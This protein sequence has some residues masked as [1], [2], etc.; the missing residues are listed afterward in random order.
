LQTNTDFLGALAIYASEPDA[1]DP[2]EVRLLEALANDLAYGVVALRNRIER[3]RAEEAL[4]RAHED[5]ERQVE[6]RTAE[7][8]RANELLKQEVVERRRAEEELQQAKE[9]AEA[10]NRAKSAFLAN[11]SHEI[12]TPMNGVIGMTELALTTRLTPQQRDYLN[13]VKHS[14]EALL[15]L[16]NDIL[17]F[18]KIEAG[19]LE[20]ET[21]E[22]RL[23]DCLGDT[24][25][26]LGMRAGQ[27]GLELAYLVPP[28][29]PD[30][31]LGDPGRL[32]Q[33]LVNLVGNAIK[34]TTRGE[35]VVA[36]MVE[37]LRE[38]EVWLHLVVSD[39]GIGIPPEKQQQVFEAFSQ[40]DSTTTRRFGGTGLGLAISRQLVSLMGGRLWLESEMGQGTTFHFVV[41]FGL[42]QGAS[43][44]PWPRPD[45]LRN[46]PVLVVDD[47]K[48]N[49][50]IL[51]DVLT[52]WGMNP[53]LA[54]NGPA[55]LARLEQAAAA[56]VPFRLALLDMMM[57]GMDGFV[58]AER[59]RHGP[60]SCALIVLTSALQPGDAERCRDVGIARCLMKPVK[61]A[62]LLDAIV[63][64]LGAHGVEETP[65]EPP[66]PTASRPLRLLL[67]EDGLV[68]QQV[69]VGLLQLR[70]HQVRVV[71]NGKEALA[72]LEQQD[73]DAVL[74]DVQMPEMDGLEA[75]RAIR[76][77]EQ[78]TGAHVRII[79]LTANA[80]KGDCEQC[81]AA[82][83]DGYLA[84]PFQ[85]EALYAAVEAC[86]P[87]VPAA[88]AGT[89]PGAVL[90]W[91]R[92]LERVGGSEELLRQLAHLF[93]KESG[94]LLAE[95][96]QAV[97]SADASRLRR[98]AHT[99]KGSADCF[100]AKPVVDAAQRL[101]FMG[102]DRNLAGT[103]E[104]RA[105]LEAE[106]DRLVRALTACTKEAV[107]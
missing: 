70:G 49:R 83:M 10:A 107:A 75:A 37:D 48:T 91:T 100:A 97:A 12:R 95:V 96:R 94:K 90:D 78:G 64:A 62:D 92:A 82:G 86:A 56:G 46:L 40:A 2:E 54:E 102:R 47:N 89:P 101:E 57:P 98:A 81:L 103:E 80:M 52:S 104:A 13:T 14:A 71:N 21:I 84:K 93:V 61:Q 36:V 32:R 51:H 77:K 19:K 44:T 99:L 67:A 25:Q 7:L 42:A 26:T 58:L 63:A 66:G 1:F 20:L 17:D 9:A 74:M 6:R 68:N 22:F 45:A 18:S 31:L 4:R 11:M 76:H 29:V 16:L 79:A 33:V 28:D 50:R 59:L 72:A 85:A 8:A 87:A 35:V 105:A 34:F 73:F 3:A 53:A 24:L 39:T 88:G 5:L 43:A 38:G 27:K 41:R 55:A 60:G 15:R 69:A 106:T 30:A 23:R 65:A